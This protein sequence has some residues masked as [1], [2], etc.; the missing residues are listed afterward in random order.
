MRT[1]EQNWWLESS[2]DDWRAFEVLKS[3]GNY[4]LAVFHLQQSAE[5]ALKALCLKHGRPG[6]THSCL[7]LLKKIIGI[8]VKVDEAVIGSTKRLDPHY[9]LSRYPN[10]VGGI[11]R[12]YYDL[13]LVEE[14][15]K[16]S[17]IIMNF[18]ELNL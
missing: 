15:E 9:I 10:G 2:K 1:Q 12:D 16:C 14:M 18:V 7:D 6:Y 11:P 3:S 8:G 13:K 5:K 17:K 4:S